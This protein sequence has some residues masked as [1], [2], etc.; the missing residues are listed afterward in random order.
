MPDLALNIILRIS[1]L[2]RLDKKAE[3]EVLISSL[4]NNSLNKYGFQKNICPGFFGW[5]T[6]GSIICQGLKSVKIPVLTVA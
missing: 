6:G 1:I 4:A 3:A 2:S 5:G